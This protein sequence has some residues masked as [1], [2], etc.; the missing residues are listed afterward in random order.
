M[1]IILKQAIRR[2]LQTVYSDAI[3]DAG[4]SYNGISL[5]LLLCY[6]NQFKSSVILTK[7]SY[8]SIKFYSLLLASK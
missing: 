6:Y 2:Y 5:L 8:F 7:L 4:V 1:N 3:Q